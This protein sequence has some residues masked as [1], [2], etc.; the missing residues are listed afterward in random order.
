MDKDFRWD[1]RVNG[2][3]MT[4]MVYNYVIYYHDSHGNNKKYIGTVTV[5]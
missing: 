3:L 5:L 4:N 1:G 2:K